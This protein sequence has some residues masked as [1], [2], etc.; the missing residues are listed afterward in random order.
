MWQKSD[1]EDSTYQFKKM[2]KDWNIDFFA[3]IDNGQNLT[4]F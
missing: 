2:W 3:E 4:G 1:T